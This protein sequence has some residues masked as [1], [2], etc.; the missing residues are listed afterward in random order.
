MKRF[1]LL[2]G[3]GLYSLQAHAAVTVGYTNDF[4]VSAADFSDPKAPGQWALTSGTYVNTIAGNAGPSASTVEVTRGATENFSM[5]STFKVTDIST[6]YSFGFAALGN[7][8]S[9]TGTTAGNKFY[10]ADI[11]NLGTTRILA[12]DGTGNTSVAVG[13]TLAFDSAKTYTLTLTGT[14][15][16]ASLVLALTVFDGTSTVSATSASIAAPLAGNF[17]GYRN[18]N[19]NAASDVYAV[20]ADDFKILVPEPS[21]LFLLGASLLGLAVKRRR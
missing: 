16:G 1:F 13:G 18:R 4:T 15:T 19:N 8:S 5:S 11:G 20:A 12:F 14:Y 21:S 2:A 10:L 9:T 17:F 7:T 6:S 3:L